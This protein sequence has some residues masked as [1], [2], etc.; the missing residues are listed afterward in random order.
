MNLPCRWSEGGLLDFSGR[1]RFRRRFG[2]PGQIDAHER[3]WLT[4]GG[5]ADQAD[6]WLNRQP[7]GHMEGT[8]AEWEFDVTEL[9]QPRNEL[10]VEVTGQGDSGGL[11]GGVALE[12]RCSAFLR[13]LHLR[14]SAAGGR[15]Q[16]H[17]SGEV[18]G[19]AD[20][21]LDLY[22]LLNRSTAAYRTICPRPEGERF[23]VL[24]PELTPKQW[25]TA[26]EDGGRTI[27]KVDLVNGGTVWYT[28]EEEVVFDDSS[29]QAK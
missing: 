26:P 3:V 18:V 4:F 14:T 6:L 10:V 9:L 15:P 11:V 22:I 20:R 27:V 12:V 5:V 7:L 16:L 19:V 1:V 28:K 13:G 24:I 23:E 8:T 17:V 25:R 29:S 2:Y 21:P